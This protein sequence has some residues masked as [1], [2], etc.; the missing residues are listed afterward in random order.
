MLMGW[1]KQVLLVLVAGRLRVEVDHRR[2]QSAVRRG[3]RNH[4]VVVGV[5]DDEV[6]HAYDVILNELG[7][8][9]GVRSSAAAS[10]LDVAS[11]IPD[12]P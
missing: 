6:D 9:G 10:L 7:V 5:P 1:G 11:S 8:G 3:G 2:L 12:P 4:K